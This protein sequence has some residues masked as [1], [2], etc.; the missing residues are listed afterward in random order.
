MRV[1][2]KYCG[3]CNPRYE[4]VEKVEKLKKQFPDTVFEAYRGQEECDKVLFVCGCERTCL[5]F[6]EDLPQ[7]KGIV[8]G[9]AQDFETLT[10]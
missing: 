7:E 4:R 1:G 8:V 10:F 6:R 9:D 3:G 5:R 2:I